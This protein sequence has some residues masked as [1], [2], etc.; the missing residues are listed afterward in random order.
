MGSARVAKKA[1]TCSNQPVLS[2]NPKSQCNYC[3]KLFSCHNKRLGTSSM[4]IHLKNTCKKYPGKFD[5]SQSK[6]NF[7][8]KKEGQMSMEEGCVGNMVIAKY[9]TT[10]IRLAIAKIIIKDELPFRFVEGEGFQDVIKTIEPRFQISFH[11]TVMKDCVKL[12]MF[13][14]EK[15]RQC[16]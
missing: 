12:F 10:K 1:K 15:L 5:K 13:E 6:L 9:Y 8:V 14:K 7:E 16:L 3:K 2:P 4:L 11:Y